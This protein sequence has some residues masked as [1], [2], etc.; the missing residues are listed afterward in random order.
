MIAARSSA[1]ELVA[2]PLA[3]NVHKNHVLHTSLMPAAVAP[4]QAAAAQAIARRIAEGFELV[5]LVAVELFETEQGLLVNELAPRPH[6]SGHVTI[7]AAVTC[8]F[9]NHIRAIHGLPLGAT[10]VAEPRVMLNLLG[11]LWGAGEP[12]WAEL[13]ADPQLQLHLYGKLEARGRRKMGHATMPVSSLD[14]A[15]DW[16]RSQALTERSQS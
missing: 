3:E 2:F 5:G 4:E 10:T 16:S 6:N 7:E 11:D 13:I 15:L 9:E 14:R 8:Q 12:D 1:G